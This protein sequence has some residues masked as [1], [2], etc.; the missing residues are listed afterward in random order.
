MALLRTE[1]TNN[2]KLQLH[3][4][5]NLAD[6]PQ[7]APPN[8]V[9]TRQTSPRA[10][11]TTSSTSPNQIGHEQSTTAP[12]SSPS[13][14]SSLSRNNLGH[15]TPDS[16]MEHLRIIAHTLRLLELRQSAVLSIRSSP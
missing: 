1:R 2:L 3:N 16:S 13:S 10:N 9:Q 4:I 8:T 6:L 7:S 5:Q 12:P 11:Q 14:P 15:I